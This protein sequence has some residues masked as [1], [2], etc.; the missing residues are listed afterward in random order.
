MRRRAARGRAGSG[1]ESCG[2]VGQQACGT[3][4]SNSREVSNEVRPRRWDFIC[5][6]RADFGVKRICQVHGVSR[7]GCYR[8]RAT[9]RVCAARQAEQ[10]VAVGEIREIHAEHHGALGA[11]PAPVL[12]RT[13]AAGRSNR[14]QRDRVEKQWPR[15]L[16]ATYVRLH[17]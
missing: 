7:S 13:E 9:T 2:A 11:P 5:D 6:Y 1:A 14:A 10:A 12:A 3:V 8:H 16:G 17:G 4:R 15:G